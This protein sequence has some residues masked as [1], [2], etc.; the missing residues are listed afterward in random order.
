MSLYDESYNDYLYA[1][2]REQERQAFEAQQHAARATT[3][4]TGF[5]YGSGWHTGAPTVNNDAQADAARQR[6]ESN[7]AWDRAK[8][9]E[10]MRGM[11]AERNLMRHEAEGRQYDRETSRYGAETQRIDSN[12]QLAGKQ[13]MV[14]GM[15]NATSAMRGVLGGLTSGAAPG[16]N[17]FGANGQR[18]GGSSP[19]QS[20]VQ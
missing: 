8:G 9:D 1:Q 16:V 3:A 19:L 5:G 15:N 7:Q 10:R 12:N 2:A 20:L 17:L 14:G 11:M 4:P 6:F 18:I 13:A